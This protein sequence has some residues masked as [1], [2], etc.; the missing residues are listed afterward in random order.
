MVPKENKHH[1]AA[2]SKSIWYSRT[3]QNFAHHT[4]DLVKM[5]G[6]ET[7]GGSLSLL[8]QRRGYH[9]TGLSVITELWILDLYL[10]AD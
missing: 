4:P 6:V 1:I 2:T 7:V 3:I 5:K 8:S 9:S 10:I